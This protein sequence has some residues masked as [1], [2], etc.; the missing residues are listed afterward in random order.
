MFNQ[1][2]VGVQNNSDGSII[3]ARGGKQ[4]DQI[5]SELHGRY[6]EQTYRGNVFSGSAVGVTTT[7]SIAVTYTGLI[8][9]NPIGS[10]KNL[11]ILSAGYSFIVAFAAGAHVG[12][13]TGFNASTNVT[14]TTPVTPRSQLFI[15]SAGSGVGLLDS[16]AQ[17][18]TAP[19]VNM[20]FGSGLT[21]TIT[22][23][24]QAGPAVID[25]AG[26]IILTP[27]SYCAFYTSTASGASGS[28]FSFVWEEVPA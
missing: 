23:A 13:M 11:A 14:H 20:I 27:G 16:S 4:G 21:G 15:G 18:P 7:V 28:G 26:Q 8:L 1:V 17:M 19:T 12:L 2:N 6:Y 5:A 24:P 10:G 9:T 3:T 25:V 22:T